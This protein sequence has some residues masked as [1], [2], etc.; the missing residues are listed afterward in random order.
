MREEPVSPR[1][2]NPSVPKDLETICLKCLTK[3]PHK[4]YGTAQELV[5]D[6]NRFLQGRPVVARPVGILGRMW[7]WGGRNPSIAALSVLSIVLLLSGTVISTWQAVRARAARDQALQQRK[8]AVEAVQR[9]A[10]ARKAAEEAVQ[11]AERAAQQQRKVAADAVQR[12]EQALKEPAAEHE[13]EIAV[14]SET[15]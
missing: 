14:G 1:T 12:A 13:T 6:L 5:D 9:E 10:Q 15:D 8:I 3:E 4:R 2:L 7:R 11:R